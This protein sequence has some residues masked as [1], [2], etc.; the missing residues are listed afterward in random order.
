MQNFGYNKILSS[1]VRILYMKKNLNHG[2]FF[3]HVFLTLF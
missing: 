3:Q 1:I 2:I